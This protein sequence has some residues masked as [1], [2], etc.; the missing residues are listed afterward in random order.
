MESILDRFKLDGR[1]AL[2]TGSARGLGRAIAE[3]LASA[4]ASIVVTS[5][6]LDVAR[7]AAE[8]I[9]RSSGGKCLGV[10]LDVR[11]QGQIEAG[12]AQALAQF[13]RIDVL[14]NN[15]GITHRGSVSELSEAQWDEVLDTNLKGAWLCSRALHPLMKDQGGGRILNIASMFCS[16]ALPERTP[17]VASK[18]GMAALTRAL[19]IEFAPDKI[20]VNA[21]APGPFQ[22]DLANQQ[23]RAGLLESIPLGRWGQ[24]SELGPAALFLCSDAAAFITG[25]TLPIDGGYTAR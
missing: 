24:A 17:Y 15:A 23:A 11:A 7:D 14:V 1:V 12:I 3:A 16:V 22:T 18:G 13:G 9:S 19:A 2:V 21:L 4:G 10:S 20:L 8:E 6:E 25:A 5:R